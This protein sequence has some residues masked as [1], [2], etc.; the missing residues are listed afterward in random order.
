MLELSTEDETRQ[1]LYFQN[2]TWLGR[3]SLTVSEEEYLMLF[4]NEFKSQS[5]KRESW[6]DDLFCVRENILYNLLVVSQ[7][8]YGDNSFLCYI[9]YTNICRKSYSR[10]WIALSLSCH[11]WHRP[12]L[13]CAHVIVVFW[14]YF[15]NCLTE[16][17]FRS[18]I[19]DFHKQSESM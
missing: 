2:N 18:F 8:Q 14:K 7:V 19:F 1:T 4:T 6:C 17:T 12:A 10:I 5:A 15:F 11:L 3:W 9:W 13:F 16:H